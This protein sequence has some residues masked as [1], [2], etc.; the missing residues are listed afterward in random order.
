MSVYKYVRPSICLSR[1]VSQYLLVR[2]N[3]FLVYILISYISYE[4]HCCILPDKRYLSHGMCL[5]QVMMT[6][7]FLNEVAN[8]T[9]STQK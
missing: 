3:A 5:Y 7:H 4:L 8:Y 6:L 2:F 9:E 1:T